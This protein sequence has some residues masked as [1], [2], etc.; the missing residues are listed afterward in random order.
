[1]TTPKNAQRPRSEKGR[2]FLDSVNADCMPKI[3]SVTVPILG[4]QNDRIVHD[5]QLKQA[6]FGKPKCR[7]VGC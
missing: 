3:D 1:M 5:R 2:Q 7:L 4:I 6:N